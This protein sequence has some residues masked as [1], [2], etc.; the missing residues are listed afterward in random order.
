DK[1]TWPVP[2]VFDFLREKGNIDPVDIYRT[3]NMGIGYIL[4]IDATE[5][6]AVIARIGEMGEKVYRIGRIVKGSQPVLLT[7]G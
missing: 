5:A 1:T 6:D 4:V 2:P 7:E 3:F